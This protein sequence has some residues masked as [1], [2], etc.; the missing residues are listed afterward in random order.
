MKFWKFSQKKFAKFS[1]QGGNIMNLIAYAC[2]VFIELVFVLGVRDLCAEF[3][4]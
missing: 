2:V 1:E 3:F 4:K